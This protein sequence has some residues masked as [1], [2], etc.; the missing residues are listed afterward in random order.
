[1]LADGGLPVL[2]AELG[3]R[4]AFQ[5]ALAAGLGVTRYAPRDTSARELRALFDEL[6][7]F[8]GDS[9]H[10][11]TKGKHPKAARRRR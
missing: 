1:M 7:A 8:A 6:V 10:E 2:G 11:E 9:T 4:I 3:D 5:E